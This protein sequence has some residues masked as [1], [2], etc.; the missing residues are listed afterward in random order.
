MTIAITIIL[1]D[2]I[3]SRDLEISSRCAFIS[4]TENTHIITQDTFLGFGEC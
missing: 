2:K 1:Y 4:P 3:K